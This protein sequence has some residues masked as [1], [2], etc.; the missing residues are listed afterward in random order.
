[1]IL[2]EDIYK[3]FLNLL[4]IGKKSATIQNLDVLSHG[5]GINF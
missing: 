4:V 5:F 3:V 1:M 2:Y